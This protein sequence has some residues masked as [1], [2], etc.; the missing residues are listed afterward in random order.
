MCPSESTA[1]EIVGSYADA[2]IVSQKLRVAAENRFHVISPATA[3]ASLPIGC[4]VSVNAMVVDPATE[5]HD[6][7]GRRSLLRNTCLKLASL[8]GLSF[9]PETSGR[10]DDRRH[11]YIVEWH[12]DSERRS[13]DNTWLVRPGDYQLDLRDG[14][15]STRKI[16][17]SV[18]AETKV[19]DRWVKRTPEEVA[20]IGRIQLRDTRAKILERAQSGAMLRAIRASLGLRAYSPAEL[21]KPFV[22]FQLS[23]VGDPRNADDRAAVRESFLGARRAAYGALA[24]PASRPYAIDTAGV[25]MGGSDGLDE[26][27]VTETHHAA[28]EPPPLQCDYCGTTHRVQAHESPKG[29]INCCAADTCCAMAHRDATRADEA[30]PPASPRP[31]SSRP[32]APRAASATAPAAPARNATTL[33][34]VHAAGATGAGQRSGLTMPFGRSKGVPVEEADG[35]DLNWMA[36]KIRTKTPSDDPRWRAKDAQLLAAIDA[37]LAGRERVDRSTNRANETGPDVPEDDI[38]F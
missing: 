26:P 25:E 34:G 13:F 36:N 4:V 14:T 22:V 12:V 33:P 30:T 5:T 23:W 38:P 35:S 7:G 18:K 21:S 29:P 37:E 10:V 24:R 28:P 16:L 27:L 19:G 6:V 32:A 2:A 31:T 9:V 1:M 11:P 15:A 3:C 17:E 8:A 20:E